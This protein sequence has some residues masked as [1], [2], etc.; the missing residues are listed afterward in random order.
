M[1]LLLLTAASL[2]ASTV[3]WAGD[4]TYEATAVVTGIS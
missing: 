2:A 1:K 4:E 3:A